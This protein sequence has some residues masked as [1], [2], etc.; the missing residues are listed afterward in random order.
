M[1]SQLCTRF[2]PSTDPCKSSLVMHP[3]HQH[4][5]SDAFLPCSSTVFV[6]Y[7][8]PQAAQSAYNAQR[9]VQGLR[10]FTLSQDPLL[11]DQYLT[12]R[13]S[14]FKCSMGSRDP[15]VGSDAYTQIRI[16]RGPRSHIVQL[17]APS[18]KA[19]A[20]GG[21]AAISTSSTSK[22][23]G[24]LTSHLYDAPSSDAPGCLMESPIITAPATFRMANKIELRVAGEQ[25]I[26][27]LSK[28]ED[29][30]KSIIELLKLASAERAH[31]M[32]VAAF[33]RRKGNAC[34]AIKMMMALIQGQSNL[35]M[36][37]FYL[38]ENMN[39]FKLPRC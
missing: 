18:S 7:N 4:H 27:D 13:S 25:F 11:L 23:T 30:P 16:P 10:V 36:Y 15:T 39:S 29:D 8:S 24:P 14:N 33:Y 5:R 1:I 17:Q 12:L 37:F 9:R 32:I 31:W 6:R 20:P 26:F 35:P 38:P 21:N 3:S 34:A 2:S 22:G 19:S 28:L